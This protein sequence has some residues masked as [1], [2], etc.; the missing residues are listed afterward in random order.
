VET[1]RRAG[2]DSIT[3]VVRPPPHSRNNAITIDAGTSAG[4]WNAQ[5]YPFH[6]QPMA[7]FEPL[8]VPWGATRRVTYRWNGTALVA[9]P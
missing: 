4:G 9:A 1:A 2:A 5:T 6:D 3:N 8:L 7:G